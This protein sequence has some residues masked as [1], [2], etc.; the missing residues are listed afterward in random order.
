MFNTK[1]CA[2]SVGDRV[3]TPCD[4]AGI[5]VRLVFEEKFGKWIAITQ[6]D[7]DRIVSHFVWMLSKEGD[8]GTSD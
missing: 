7:D 2:F 5:I 4:G 8:D 3:L 6:L 1:P